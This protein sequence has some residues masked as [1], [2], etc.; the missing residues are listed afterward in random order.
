M[1]KLKLPK[2]KQAT[3]EDLI[4][5]LE[6][7]SHREMKLNLAQA[8]TN[9][10]V[11]KAFRLINAETAR[12]MADQLEILEAIEAIVEANPEWFKDRKSIKCPF[13]TVSVRESTGIEIEDEI[14]TLQKIEKSARLA[15]DQFTR[16]NREIDMNAL[17]KLSDR[18]LERIGAKRKTENKVSV[19]AGQI[20]IRKLSEAEATEAAA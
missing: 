7:N 14:E 20:D 18:D 3:R 17:K 15:T 1:A 10:A 19:K 13:G 8:K 16:V 4:K 9:E 11:A 5:L 12:M 6:E 2:P